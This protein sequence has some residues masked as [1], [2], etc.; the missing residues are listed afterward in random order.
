M[1]QSHNNSR[2][3]LQKA[4][5]A[6]HLALHAHPAFARLLEADVTQPEL[7]QANTLH[8]TAFKAIETA[9]ETLHVWED[10]TLRNAIT[11]L[12]ADIGQQDIE[13]I[14]LLLDT[15][16][17]TLGALYVAHGSSF[18]GNVIGRN[19]RAALPEASIEFYAQ[20]SKTT[21]QKLVL[22]LEALTGAEVEDAVVGAQSTFGWYLNTQVSA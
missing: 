16:A 12:Q 11:A 10:L 22:T 1:A 7:D 15:R 19:L 18:G 2:K 5:E 14:D 9:R 4:T 8:L 17:Q 6:D 13:H 3:Y 20:K 21:W